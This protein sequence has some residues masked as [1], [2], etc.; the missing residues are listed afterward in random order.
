MQK[1]AAYSLVVRRGMRFEIPLNG[2]AWTYI[3]ATGATEG[4]LYQNR[5]YEASKVFF[6]FDPVVVGEYLLEFNRQDVLLDD[7]E[8]VFVRVIVDPEDGSSATDP[9]GAASAPIAGS[10]PVPG[11]SAATSPAP[12]SPKPADATPSAKVANA[13]APLPAVGVASPAPPPGQLGQ[14]QTAVSSTD[15]VNALDAAALL[16]KAQKDLDAGK[17]DTAQEALDAYGSRY[18]QGDEYLYWAAR[19]YESPGPQRDILKARGLYAQLM[20]DF[21]ESPR[22]DAADAK[23]EYIDR[24]YLQ[25]R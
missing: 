14:G 5:K 20:Q 3:G 10:S 21:P 18:P 24:H 25:I 23:I 1:K 16:K 8:T 11:S 6:V 4:I 13:A 9:S 15:D 17:L 12:D 7:I 2:T 19:F 22:Y